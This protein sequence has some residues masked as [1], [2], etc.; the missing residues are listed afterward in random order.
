MADEFDQFKRPERTLSRSAEEEEFK[1]QTAGIPG[2]PSWLRPLSKEQI[3]GQFNTAQNLITPGYM[4]DKIEPNALQHV[5][6]NIVGSTTG[7]AIGELAGTA[8]GQ[9]AAVGLSRGAERVAR[10]ALEP[11]KPWSPLVRFALGRT[12]TVLESVLRPTVLAR[13]LSGAS[14]VAGPAAALGVPGMVG[15]V[16][17]GVAGGR[18]LSRSKQEQSDEFDQYKR[19]E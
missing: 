2:I 8:A 13:L 18:A 7:G 14:R 1:R 19:N 4:Q 6:E 17:G 9:G 5:A 16:A 15:T 12:G 10:A 11:S 3:A